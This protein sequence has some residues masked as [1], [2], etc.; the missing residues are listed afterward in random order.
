[1]AETL[2]LKPVYRVCKHLQASNQVPH[3]MKGVIFMSDTY[4]IVM[5]DT[6]ILGLCCEP[7]G[8]IRIRK[9]KKRQKRQS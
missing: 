7:K 4:G 5:N 2:I 1:M 3:L 9:I 8:G 6:A